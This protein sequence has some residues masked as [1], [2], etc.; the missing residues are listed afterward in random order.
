M[1]W[2]GR[3]KK[4]Q[5]GVLGLLPKVEGKYLPNEQLNKY[6]WFGVG[7]PAEVMYC[8][9]NDNDL[10]NFMKNKPYNLPVFVIGGGSNLL[11][12]DGGIPGV[13]IKLKSKFY[14]KWH[15]EDDCIVCGAGMKNA[16]LK[17]IMANNGIGGLEFLVSIPGELGGAVKTNA[18]CFGKELKDVLVSA[19]VVNSEG[20]LLE[21]VADDFNLGYR[22][23][24]FPE[25]WVITS[26]KLKVCKQNSE[27]TLKIIDEHRAYRKKS[28]PI[29]V[30]TAGSTFKNPEGLRAWELIKKTGSNNFKVNDAEVSDVHCNFL[31]NKGNA[32]A[33]D[34][35]ELGNKIIENVKEQTS[36]TLE[37]EVKRVGVVK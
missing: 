5:V 15:L 12:R 11:V 28:Q 26:M 18:G 1:L 25:D 22:C 34:I 4:Q 14:K 16:E 21:V 27:E 30:K 36:I 31:I 3:K 37:W 7:G 10:Q 20:E 32:S 35:E 19:T 23:S 6:T 13:V 17:K 24:Y 2:F 29:N 9:E 33:Q 8:P